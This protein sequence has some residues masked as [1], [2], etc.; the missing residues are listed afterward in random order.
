MPLPAAPGKLFAAALGADVSQIKC[1][2]EGV[3]L[4]GFGSSVGENGMLKVDQLQSCWGKK[5]AVL[6]HCLGLTSS[7]T[8]YLVAGSANQG[9]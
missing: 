2:E 8:T 3:L 5:Y 4:A 9:G 1:E 7:Y 6:S